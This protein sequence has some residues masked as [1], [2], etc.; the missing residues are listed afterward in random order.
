MT[1][2]YHCLVSGLPDVT[3]DDG[4]L[5]VS[6]AGFIEEIE[7]QLSAS[8]MKL[9]NLFR[10]QYDN[11]NLL[12]YL[13]NK[14][15][16]FHPLGIYTADD[17]EEA[18]ISIKEEEPYKG[19]LPLYLHGFIHAYI[20]SEQADQSIQPE[21]RLATLYYDYATKDSGSF[22]GEWFIFNLNI[23][24]LLTAQ[25]ARK[26]GIELQ[27]VIVGN[28][29][30][31]IAIKTIGGR[32]FGLTGTLDYFEPVMRITEEANLYERE[33]KIDLLRWKWLEENSFFHYFTIE[34][35]FSYMLQLDMIE[36][37]LN[38]NRETGEEMFRGMIAA[39]KESV[40]LPDEF[41]NN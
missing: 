40:E 14:E 36:R 23:G 16:S 20:E 18:I 32:D 9:I 7:G 41:R 30:V 31:A 3:F 22:V 13:N 21:D 33:R 39:M 28:N 29:D 24:N 27:K 12:A 11:S 1:N 19:T 15:T 10:L 5:S 6:V 8:D 25:A 37:W 2:N 38:L 26:M 4:K 35:I 34:K 17:F